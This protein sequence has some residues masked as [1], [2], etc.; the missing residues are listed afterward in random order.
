MLRE[1]TSL[2]LSQ[3]ALLLLYDIFKVSLIQGFL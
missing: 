2:G 1:Q 3:S